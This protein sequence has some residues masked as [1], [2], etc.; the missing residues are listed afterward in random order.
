MK[1]K[2]S[3]FLAILIGLFSCKNKPVITEEHFHIPNGKYLG[4]LDIQGNDLP[5]IFEI[6]SN[7][8]FILYNGEESFTI[9]NPEFEADSVV[10][11]L[12]I[13]DTK[14]TLTWIETEAT[15]IG[16]WQ[17]NYVKDY[18][19]KLYAQP[20]KEEAIN[21]EEAI[22]AAF[23]DSKYR[24]YFESMLSDSTVSIG[25][26]SQNSNNLSG[27]FLTTTGDYRYLR[28]SVYNNE[29][30]LFTFDGEHAFV[31]TAEV[32]STGVINGHFYSGKTWHETWTAFPD[33]NVEL[34]DASTLTYLNEGFETV[35]FSGIG[36]KGDSINLKSV[37]FENK[38]LIVQIMGTWCPNCMDET[39]FLSQWYKNQKPDGIEVVSLAFERKDNFQYAKKR[40][41]AL[42]ERYDIKYPLLFVGG[43]DKQ[44]AAEKLPA[45]SSVI[46]YPTLIFMDKDHKATHIHTGFNGPG[47]GEYYER[48]KLDFEK[49][50]N[51]LVN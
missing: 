38:A 2:F 42:K 22:G 12:H 14:L 25:E 32:D 35:D 50:V 24:V 45:L 20:F 15:F 36:L 37:E 40:L 13:F 26:F 30:K 27:T 8:N 23:L 41:N 4:M 5:F 1:L 28:G 43:S 34:E 7:R 21:E 39:A 44:E 51:E 6:D 31:F 47:T 19:I 46:A 11:P 18:K 33:E 10:V 3:I 48:W 9:E 29:L 49:R 16:Y 17:K